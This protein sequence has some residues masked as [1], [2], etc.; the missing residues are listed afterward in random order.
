MIYSPL[1]KSTT[2]QQHPF[3]FVFSSSRRFFSSP[4]FRVIR[5]YFDTFGFGFCCSAL[6]DKYGV[7][8]GAWEAAW[9]EEEP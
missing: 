8:V 1:D 7:A 5:F 9:T 2:N 4:A 6:G 3:F